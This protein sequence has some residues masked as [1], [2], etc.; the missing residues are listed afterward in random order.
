MEQ[1]NASLHES[2]GN[3]D[4]SHL[5]GLEFF[6]DRPHFAK[7]VEG[8]MARIEE[9]MANNTDGAPAHTFESPLPEKNKDKQHKS[10]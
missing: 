6:E 5:Q 2:F 4:S 1:K 8:A 3:V 10:P 7:H 9:E